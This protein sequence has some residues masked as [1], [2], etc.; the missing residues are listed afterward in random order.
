V[1]LLALSLKSPALGRTQ[2]AC[3]LGEPW[4][5]LNRTQSNRARRPMFHSDCDRPRLLSPSALAGVPKPCL[6]RKGPRERKEAAECPTARCQR[7]GASE[8]D[9]V[10]NLGLLASSRIERR[11]F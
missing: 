4:T 1:C 9:N 3:Q 7:L 5:F 2:Q 10:T 11:F 6:Q 8:A